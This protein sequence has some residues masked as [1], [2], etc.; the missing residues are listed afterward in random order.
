MTS[1]SETSRSVDSAPVAT[2]QRLPAADILVADRLRKALPDRVETMAW[3][4]REEGQLTPIEVVITATGP[5][6][7]DG[8]VRIAAG[9]LA[10][11][12]EIDAIVHPLG[13][14]GSDLDIRQREITETIV[15]FQLTALERAVYIAEWRALHE[16]KFPP[17]KRGR[18]K[19]VVDDETLEE[20]SANFALNFTDTVQRTLGLGRRAIFL[21]L[22]IATLPTAIRDRIAAHA[23][24]DNQAE[25]LALAGQPEGMLA[26]IV[27]LILDGASSVADAVATLQQLPLPSKLLPHE[28]LS[29]GF[30]RLKQDQQFAF[31]DLHADAIDLWRAQRVN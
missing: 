30:S 19:A 28:K 3:S 2:L 15:R 13:A 14:F 6:L 8:A 27:Q 12:T 20:L 9:Q 22:K 10:G 24:A 29:E 21:D 25:L 4:F 18:R 16:Q 1:V 17:A 31:F 26:A 7:I 23:M 5:R 11:W